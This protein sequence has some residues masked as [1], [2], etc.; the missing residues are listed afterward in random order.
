MS[1]S[2]F[3]KPELV[4]GL[5]VGFLFLVFITFKFVWKRNVNVKAKKGSVA[6]NGENNGDITIKSRK[7]K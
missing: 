5:A 1:F 2:L 7:G 3:E 4:I 6:I